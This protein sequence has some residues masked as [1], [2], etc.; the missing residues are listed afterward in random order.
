MWFGGGNSEIATYL[1][2]PDS[3]IVTCLIQ[4]GSKTAAYRFRQFETATFIDQIKSQNA[5]Y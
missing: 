2:Q 3:E 1:I 5:V 4:P